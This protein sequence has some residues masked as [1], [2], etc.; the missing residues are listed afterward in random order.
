MLSALALPAFTPTQVAYRNSAIASA[1]AQELDDAANRPLSAAVVA[2]VDSLLGLPP[3]DPRL[4][5]R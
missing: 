4:G 5:V 2:R 3:S 1:R